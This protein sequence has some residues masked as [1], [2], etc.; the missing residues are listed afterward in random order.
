MNT[1]QFKAVSVKDNSTKE[2][3]FNSGSKLTKQI[4]EWLKN[5]VSK[6]TIH[7]AGKTFD[8]PGMTAT[9][10][11]ERNFAFIK[12]L[13]SVTFAGV[14][15]KTIP[16]KSWVTENLA[17]SFKVPALSLNCFSVLLGEIQG[18]YRDIVKS[19]KL[20]TQTMNKPIFAA[21]VKTQAELKAAIESHRKAFP[22][23]YVET[24]QLAPAS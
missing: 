12:G 13:L 10:F 20:N 19:Q 21:R 4:A 3:S 8:V 7:Y 1:L 18:T 16:V 5:Q 17:T 15:D 9:N 22:A 6:V 11:G 24:K 2:C 23:M 14:A